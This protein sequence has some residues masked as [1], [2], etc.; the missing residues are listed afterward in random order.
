MNFKNQTIWI[1]GASSGIGEALA[2]AFSSKGARLIL[3]AR[4]TNE[5]ERVKSHC[6]YP[7]QVHIL[8]LDLAEYHDLNQ[9]VKLALQQVDQ[10]DIL[11]NNGGISQRALVQDLELPVLDRI[12]Q[13]NFFGAAALTQALLPHFLERKAGHFVCISSLMGKFS[14]PL[15]SG[16]CASKHALHGFY[17]ALRAEVHDH[18]I[19]V[20]LICPGFIKTKVSLN[21]L[22]GDGHKQNTMDP[23]SAKGMPPEV[24]AQK[25]LKAIQKKKPEVYIGGKEVMGVYLKRFFP[26]LLR[27]MMRKAQV[28]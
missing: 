19:A 16:Y 5:L 1:T 25:I 24:C 11:I 14:S 15:R 4:R 28:I 8:A 13:V 18:Q 21:A 20:S 6:A 10:I 27:R 9:K 17:D 2:Y 22:L 3:S 7:E 23:S 26:S 12:M